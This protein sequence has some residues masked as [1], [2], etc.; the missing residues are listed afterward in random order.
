M[1]P[2]NVE[3]QVIA[4]NALFGDVGENGG[5]VHYF[6]F[7]AQLE[8]ESDEPTPSATTDGPTTEAPTTDGPTDCPSVSPSE[9]T[10]TPS[11]EPS[12]DA[13]TSDAPTTDGPT[14][15]VPSASESP[16]GGADETTGDCVPLATTGSSLG[17]VV[18]GAVALVVVGAGVVA[19]ASMRRRGRQN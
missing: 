13:P 1:S 8:C 5:E 2:E 15:A 3:G 14:T 18:F 11:E 17:P 7:R 16:S 4:K 6:P 9:S 19:A 10:G 12:T